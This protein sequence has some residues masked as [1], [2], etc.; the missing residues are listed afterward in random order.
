MPKMRKGWLWFDNDP[1]TTVEEKVQRA[2]E[3]YHEKFGRAPTT[4]CVHPQAVDGPLQVGAVR[5]V[6]LGH[7]LRCHFWLGEVV[8]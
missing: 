8:L 6:P 1:A 3:R 5:V 2:A 4:C 7:V